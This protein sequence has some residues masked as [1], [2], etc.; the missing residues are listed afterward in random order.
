MSAE[1]ITAAWPDWEVTKI[2]GK[3]SFGTVYEAVR[4]S[5]GFWSWAAI[6]VISIPCDEAE[7]ENLR[8]EGMS[9][10]ESR[11]Y[12]KGIVDEFTE[13]IQMMNAFKGVQNIV[14]VEDY[15]VVERQDRIGWDILIRMELLTPL[16][17]YIRQN[18]LTQKD[19]IKIGKDICTALELCARRN[20][21]HRDI[22]PENIF[23]NSFGDFKLGD[24]GVARKLENMTSGLSQKGTYNYMAPEVA[25]GTRYDA[26]VDLYSLGLVLYR[27]L[28]DNRLPFIETDQQ[29]LSA[30]ARRAAVERRIRGERLSMPSQAIPQLGGVI[31]RACAFDP[32]QRFADATQ[33][34][35]ALQK[36]ETLL[37]QQT[38]QP[39]SKPEP[40]QTFQPPAQPVTPAKRTAG[41][42][43]AATKPA[44]RV[45]NPDGTVAVR[46]TGTNM[47]QTVRTH[48]QA[49]RTPAPKSGGKQPRSKQ[50]WTTQE[51]DNPQAPDSSDVMQDVPSICGVALAF[52]WMPVVGM[53][54]ALFARRAT[55][56]QN[57]RGK[58]LALMGFLISLLFFV[59]LLFLDG[60][61][62]LGCVL[63]GI[64]VVC[65]ALI[66]IR[67]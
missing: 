28:N 54:L 20:I 29:R 15:Q 30:S 10:A 17:T 26:R 6:K 25:T 42:A 21:V 8:A 16:T 35:A 33:M 38:N 43:E 2:L 61:A 56:P 58:G 13:E 49:V 65:Y 32:A 39:V 50:E 40:V 14:S 36:A 52:C 55:R 5:G 22:K 51:R 47:N 18:T 12:F 67:D 64:S 37:G 41:P 1:Q 23:V 45:Q 46:R 66:G 4:K 24:F 53:I 9:E 11:T 27:F 34:K 59:G 44:P 3:G 63:I 60:Y 57:V 62:G 7:L 48:P 19:V 31:L